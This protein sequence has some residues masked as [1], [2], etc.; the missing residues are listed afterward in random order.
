MD[1]KGFIKIVYDG[2]IRTTEFDNNIDSEDFT[3]MLVDFV[4]RY[5]GRAFIYGYFGECTL[6]FSYM[7][8]ITEHNFK[9]LDELKRWYLSDI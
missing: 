9:S 6:I 5:I 2:N 4:I 8:N 1:K 7:D 3:D